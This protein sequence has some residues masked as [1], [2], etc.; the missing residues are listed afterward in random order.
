M[1]LTLLIIASLAFYIVLGTVIAV[2]VAP[3]EF[4][5]MELQDWLADRIGEAW[6]TRMAAVLAVVVGLPVAVS[7][8]YAPFGLIR[9]WGKHR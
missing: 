2:A 6:A 7:I 3:V 1:R 5:A 4:Y 9:L 8:I